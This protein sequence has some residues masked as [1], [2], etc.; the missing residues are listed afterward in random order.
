MTED[1]TPAGSSRVRLELNA[2]G[3]H[4]DPEMDRLLRLRDEDPPRFATL[5]SSS[6]SAVE[7][8]SDMKDHYTRAVAGGAIPDDRGPAAA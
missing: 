2:R 1:L 7:I 8:Y 4:P 3:F 5:P 6:L